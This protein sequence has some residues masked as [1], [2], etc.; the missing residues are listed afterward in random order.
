MEEATTI[1]GGTA[2]SD[3]KTL[4]PALPADDLPGDNS[5][6]EDLRKEVEK[7]QRSPDRCGILAIKSGNNWVEDGINLPDPKVFYYGL[8]VQYEITALF[9][10]TGSGKTVFAMQIAEEISRY[11]KILYIDLE[12][13]VKQF[14]GR[15]TDA[16]NGTIHVFPENFLRAEIDPEFITRED[17]EAEILD[18]IEAAAKKGITFFVLDNITFACNDSEK[19]S[20][21]GS[22][23]MRL[24][25]LKKKYFLTIICVAHTPKIK[26]Y[27]R[28]TPNHM[29]GSAKLMNFFDEG[30]AIGK[31]AR[32]SRL[33]YVKQVKTRSQETTYD[34]EYV[35]IYEVT[36]E[37][38]ILRYEFRGH[39]KEDEHLKQGNPADDIDEIYAILR[40]QRDGKTLR[41]IATALEISLGKVQRRLKKAKEENITLPDSETVPVSD[42]SPVSAPIQTIQ[43]IQEPMQGTLPGL[44]DDN[45][46]TKEE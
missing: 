17:M 29:A 9:G 1:T 22:F 33:R 34:E 32:D 31:S 12:L 23:M 11:Y 8:I 6:V 35:I 5:P 27:E 20:T 16:E 4:I 10:S 40:L 42:V 15:Y 25:R 45:T 3:D 39:G 37:N 28:L 24:I 14:Q 13:S 26:G 18:S 7:A 19:G 36:K 21:A 41:E 43:T 2:M 30:I 38:G 46:K 44:A